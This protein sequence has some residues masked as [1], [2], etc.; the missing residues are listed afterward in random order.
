MMPLN[1]PMNPMQGFYPQMQMCKAEMEK[2]LT[3]LTTNRMISTEQ[4][5]NLRNNF[6]SWFNAV[7]TEW[8]STNFNMAYLNNIIQKYIVQY[9]TPSTFFSPTV[10]MGNT[11]IQSNP[12]MMNNV[13]PVMGSN[14]PFNP[15]S[16]ADDLWGN[17]NNFN[18]AQLPTNTQKNAKI[19]Q[20]QQATNIKVNQDAMGEMINKGSGTI[21]APII[22]TNTTP[23][24]V[25][26]IPLP[27]NHGLSEDRDKKIS[28]YI[29][30]VKVFKM[31]IN[32]REVMMNEISLSDPMNSIEHTIN[33]VE[34]SFPE[35][36]SSSEFCTN[37]K[38]GELHILKKD[39]PYTTSIGFMDNFC[40]KYAKVKENISNLPMLIH[41]LNAGG[42][43]GQKLKKYAY[44]LFNEYSSVFLVKKCSDNM[45]HGMRPLVEDVDINFY[46]DNSITDQGDFSHELKGTNDA[47]REIYIRRLGSIISKSFGSLFDKDDSIKYLDIQNSYHRQYILT[48]NKVGYRFGKE[49]FCSRTVQMFT[50]LDEEDN[51]NTKIIS[52]LNE[53]FPMIFSQKICYHNLN[54]DVPEWYEPIVRFLGISNTTAIFEKLIEMNNEVMV[55]IDTHDRSQIKHPIL[56]GKTYEDI[57]VCKRMS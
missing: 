27:K 29:N 24:T 55:T 26:V 38:Y 34:D 33:E 21:S 49:N 17:K 47:D 37:I 2:V 30:R 31:Q 28:D 57:L 40:D 16:H 8:Y 56:I 43:L 36:V 39:A 19:T 42:I 53:I 46:I 45:Y 14:V 23:S 41:E 51:L 52:K 5:N 25:K 35:A 7:W 1:Q 50:D 20:E 9:S 18:V 11:Y 44:Y 4:S 54:L 6:N 3:Y 12:Y 15:M 13:S 22:D 48:S 32:T 10:N